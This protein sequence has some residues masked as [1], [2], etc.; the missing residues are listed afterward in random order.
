[1]TFYVQNA[2]LVYGSARRSAFSINVPTST[3]RLVRILSP[4]NSRAK[5]DQPLDRRQGE[6]QAWFVS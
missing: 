1:M 4:T 3:Q 6:A 2:T 5:G